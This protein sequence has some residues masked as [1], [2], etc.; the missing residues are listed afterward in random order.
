MTEQLLSITYEFTETDHLQVT[1]HAEKTDGTGSETEP[2]GTLKLTLKDGKTGQIL[3]ENSGSGF[4]PLDC[5]STLNIS[6]ASKKG[7]SY[8]ALVQWTPIGGLT[9]RKQL[10]IEIE[11]YEGK[12]LPYFRYTLNAKA[13]TG[14]TALCSLQDTIFCL[15]TADGYELTAEPE[16][17]LLEYIS[18]DGAVCTYSGEVFWDGHGHSFPEQCLIP[19][20]SAL[21]LALTVSCEAAFQKKGQPLTNRKTALKFSTV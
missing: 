21:P 2:R 18:R 19:D 15:N 14:R 1:A 3:Q 10:L 5:S 8:K 6:T 4:L 9:K 7:G 12:I 20:D 11:G 17:V 13:S 16:H